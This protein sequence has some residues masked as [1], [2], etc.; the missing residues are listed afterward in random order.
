VPRS[1][2]APAQIKTD[3][4]RTAI[5]RARAQGKSYAELA[6]QFGLSVRRIRDI[7][8]EEFKRL[9]TERNAAAVEAFQRTM[10]RLDDLLE[11]VWG[12]ALQGDPKAVQAALSV[13]DRQ[14]R[15]HG[16][17]GT[18]SGDA[19]VTTQ[20]NHFYLEQRARDL[21]VTVD[22]LRGPPVPALPAAP[23]IDAEVVD[24]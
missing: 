23:V 10:E 6:R 22:A 19:P 5:T 15:L 17:I 18:S 4:R 13:I 24:R 1:K 7:L 11:A 16:L 12:D 14:A 2:T 9:S 20:V 21:G 3:E 8:G